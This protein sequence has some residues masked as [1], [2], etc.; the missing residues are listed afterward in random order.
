[1]TL[2]ADTFANTGAN[3]GAFAEAAIV[4]SRNDREQRDYR[5]AVVIIALFISSASTQ[6]QFRLKDFVG[7]NI[8]LAVEEMTSSLQSA[9]AFIVSESQR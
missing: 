8:P 7:E 6:V 2:G 1:M 5:T 4:L 3:T 9:A